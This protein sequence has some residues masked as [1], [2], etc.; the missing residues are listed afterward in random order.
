MK[1]LPYFV[2]AGALV[3]GVIAAAVTGEWPILIVVAI[4]GAGYVL[5]MRSRASGGEQTHDE[6]LMSE[7]P[8][9]RRASR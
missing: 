4:V 8:R 9:R 2:V 6:Q 5:L 3:L 7:V 1:L